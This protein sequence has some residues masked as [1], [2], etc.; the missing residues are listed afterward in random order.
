MVWLDGQPAQID[1]S[2]GGNRGS[3]D[4]AAVLRTRDMMARGAMA[5]AA[6]RG[7]RQENWTRRP[8]RYTTRRSRRGSWPD[9]PERQSVTFHACRREKQGLHHVAG[10]IREADR[11]PRRP[12]DIDVIVKG[13]TLLDQRWHRNQRRSERWVV[14]Q[15]PTCA[16][17]PARTSAYTSSLQDRERQQGRALIRQAAMDLREPCSRKIRYD[18]LF[19]RR[20]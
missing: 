20:K 10:S 2:E 18:A 8:R 16:T 15:E 19:R 1:D 7:G 3:I 14:V 6:H 12:D 17:S 13:I 11:Q 9:Y 4:R 5:P